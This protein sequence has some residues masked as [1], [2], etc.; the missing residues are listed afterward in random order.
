VVENFL[1]GLKD[2][3]YYTFIYVSIW[4]IACFFFTMLVVTY[5]QYDSDNA[6]GNLFDLFEATYSQRTI[7]VTEVRKMF[8]DIRKSTSVFNLL[9]PSGNFTY[10][11]V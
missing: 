6:V 1:Q 9:K 11:Q 7:N 4:K 2:T 10:H 3:R 5:I 8:T